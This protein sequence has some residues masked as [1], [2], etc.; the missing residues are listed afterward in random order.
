M[1]RKHESH[2]YI[3]EIVG[4][5]RLGNDSRWAGEDVA[6]RKDNKKRTRGNRR[7]RHPT[8]KGYSRDRKLA[9]FPMQA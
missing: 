2:R 5:A 1:G 4:K 8:K 9:A 3:V 7:S 6:P